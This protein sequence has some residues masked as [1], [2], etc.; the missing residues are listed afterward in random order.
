MVKGGEG[1]KKSDDDW[2]ESPHCWSWP[3]SLEAAGTK[4]MIWTPDMSGYKANKAS[5]GKQTAQTDSY[6][7]DESS[8]C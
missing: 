7:R 8:T 4:H 2:D 1:G 6:P 5:K 3:S